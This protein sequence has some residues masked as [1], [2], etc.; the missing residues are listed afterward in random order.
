[1]KIFWLLFVPVVLAPVYV[2]AQD[3]LKTPKEC[4]MLKD[5]IAMHGVAYESGVDVH[6]KPVVPADINAQAIDVPDT[7]V[8]PLTVDIAKRLSPVPTANKGVGMEGTL[9]FLEILKSGQVMFNGQDV[10]SQVYALC[11]QK[12]AEIPAPEAV[13]GD[14]QKQ[15]AVIKLPPKEEVVTSPSQ[16]AVPKPE[17]KPYPLGALLQGEESNDE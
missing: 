10:T 2:H 6:G 11:G 17:T 14:G 9:G 13:L 3:V 4:L 15:E 16:Q 8:V 1:M 5:H 7:M 12:S